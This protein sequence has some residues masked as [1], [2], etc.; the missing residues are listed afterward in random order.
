MRWSTLE[1]E[2]MSKA[3]QV[4]LIPDSGPL[5][6]LHRRD[7]LATLFVRFASLAVPD[8]VV[9]D[10]V[11]N[12]QDEGKAIAKWISL[13][14]V[15]ILDTRTFANGHGTGLENSTLPQGAVVDLCLQEVMNEI[16]L[17]NGKTSAVFLLEEHKCIGKDTFFAGRYCMSVTLKAF[18]KFLAQTSAEAVAENPEPTPESVAQPGTK[19]K[20][21]SKKKSPDVQSAPTVTPEPPPQKEAIKEGNFL[22]AIEAANPKMVEKRLR[23]LAGQTSKISQKALEAF[24]ARTV[25][26]PVGPDPASVEQFR[27]NLQ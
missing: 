3:S 21:A 20:L 2:K 16:N 25:E 14:N 9:H 12:A 23:E 19:A 10:L 11:R 8:A 13:N 15:P 4:I 6:E 27:K 22:S 26:K 1:G 5:L 7:G 17:S 24:R 18:E